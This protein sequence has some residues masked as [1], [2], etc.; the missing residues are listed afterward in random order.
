MYGNLRA[1]GFNFTDNNDIALFML[2]IQCRDFLQNNSEKYGLLAEFFIDEGK[3]KAGTLQKI[4]MLAD[5]AADSILS[6]KS[7]CDE[8]LIQIADFIAFST[9]R[10]QMIAVKE[11]KSK[12]DIAFL[13]IMSNIDINAIGLIKN[14]M[15]EINSVNYDNAI[16]LDKD[17]KNILSDE[18]YEKIKKR[19]NP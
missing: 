15:K 19:F 17:N 14:T 1:E 9:N 12:T 16:R 13:K 7:S 18:D 11:N 4:S 8:I 5:V 3:K 6:Y 2:L 10:I